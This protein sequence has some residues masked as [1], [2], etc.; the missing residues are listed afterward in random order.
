MQE[1]QKFTKMEIF[2]LPTAQEQE[3]FLECAI[4]RRPLDAVQEN[5]EVHDKNCNDHARNTDICRSGLETRLYKGQSRLKSVPFH[6]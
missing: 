2:T 3:E 4:S 6:T 1:R 5:Q